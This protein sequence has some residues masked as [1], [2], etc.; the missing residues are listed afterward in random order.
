M[1]DLIITIQLPDALVERAK[2]AGI[3]LDTQAEDFITLLES[4]IRKQESAQALRTIAEQIQA[5][6]EELRPSLEEIEAE[7]EDYWAETEA[8]ANL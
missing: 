3:Q 2:R 5:L 6:P 7:I 8:K 4:Q 1:S